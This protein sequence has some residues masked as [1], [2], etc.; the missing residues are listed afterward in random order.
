M[1]SLQSPF[2]PVVTAFMPVKTSPE[3]LGFPVDRR[4]KLLAEHFTPI[5]RTLV[6]NVSP[7]PFAG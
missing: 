1:A 3:W 4:L 7:N 5:L 2:E 6:A